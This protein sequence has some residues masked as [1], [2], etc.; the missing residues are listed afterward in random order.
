[1]RGNHLYA[2]PVALFVALSLLGCGNLVLLSE[3]TYPVLWDTATVEVIDATGL[4][5]ADLEQVLSESEVLARFHTLSPSGDSGALDASELEKAKTTARTLGAN[6]VLFTKDSETIAA[7]KQDARF[8]GP[9]DPGA[10]VF[11]A[12]RKRN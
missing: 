2:V 7:I 10:V 6:V 8:A 3:A 1:M 12:M 11:Y 5:R 4:S 9:T